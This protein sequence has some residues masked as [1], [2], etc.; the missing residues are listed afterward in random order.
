MATRKAI[1]FDK[2]GTLFDFGAS[3]GPWAEAVLSEI[4]SLVPGV[5]E[6]V[7][8]AFGFDR[9]TGAF[10][11]DSVVI[12]G[13]TEDTVA[14]IESI[15]PNNVPLLSILDKHAQN[16]R[17]QPVLGLHVTLS[18]LAEDF[19]LGVVT[20]DG[21]TAARKHLE[22]HGISDLFSFVAGYDSGFGSKPAPGQLLAFCEAT[23]VPP[24]AC[25]MVGDSLHDLIAGRSAGM[26]TVGVL[27]GIADQTELSPHA[28]IVM[29]DIGGLRAWLSER[30]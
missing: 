5:S 26:E 17:Q 8:R 28:D 16:V 2:D 23:N 12:A 4:E 19:V 30:D 14:A 9:I 29:S 11:P 18:D 10:D 15:V 25:V 7:S 22:L 6:D 13:T 27:T 20:N 3:W 1:I 21:A 24:S